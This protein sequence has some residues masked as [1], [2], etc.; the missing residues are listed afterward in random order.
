MTTMYT[1]TA[2]AIQP[3]SPS[4]LRHERGFML[5]EM[6][7]A[8]F[9]FTIGMLAVSSMQ[10]M[11]IK[12]NAHANRMA[13]ATYFA[14]NKVEELRNTTDLTTLVS[15]TETSVSPSTSSNVVFNRRWNITAGPTAA[16]RVVVVFVEWVSGSQTKVVEVS[17]LISGNDI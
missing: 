11:A 17:T 8:M 2:N 14:Q 12:T 13:E 16:S 6:M 5:V 4:R 7:I 1:T 15:G 9:I 10:V 3:M